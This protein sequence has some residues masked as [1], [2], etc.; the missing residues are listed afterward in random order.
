MVHGEAAAPRDGVPGWDRRRRLGTGLPEEAASPR[1]GHRSGAGEGQ[2][3]RRG[4]AHGGDDSGACTASQQP[5]V[6]EEREKATPEFVLRFDLNGAQRN[7]VVARRRPRRSPAAREREGK[8]GG[9]GD[10]FAKKVLSFLRFANG[11][12][13]SE[14]GGLRGISGAA[15][16]FLQNCYGDRTGT[17]GLEING[18]ERVAHC[19][20]PQ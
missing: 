20:G 1:F 5:I 3:R 8:G 14:K 10:V 18:A 9:C 13:S 19:S 17:V 11:S 7:D 2:T 16:L 6:G 4:S 12:L 15:C